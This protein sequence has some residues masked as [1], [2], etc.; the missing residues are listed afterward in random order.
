MKYVQSECNTATAM[1]L[2]ESYIIDGDHCTDVLTKC[3][4]MTFEKDKGPLTLS[5]QEYIDAFNS[6]SEEIPDYGSNFNKSKSNAFQFWI[7]I[8][9]LLFYF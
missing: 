9:M 7:I 8:L 5:Y 4:N 6:Y 3:R 2:C 1:K